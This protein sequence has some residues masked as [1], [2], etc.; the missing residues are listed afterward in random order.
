M[1]HIKQNAPILAIEAAP[2]KLDVRQK[3]KQPKNFNLTK[4]KPKQS[5]DEQIKDFT[6]ASIVRISNAPAE[7]SE[8]DEF[9]GVTD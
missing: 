7:K 3:L 2:P 8:S 1:Q 4:A 9:V 6:M 5:F